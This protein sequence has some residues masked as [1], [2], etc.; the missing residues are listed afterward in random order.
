MTCRKKSR[1]VCDCCSYVMYFNDDEVR[2]GL[3]LA[4]QSCDSC[5]DVISYIFQMNEYLG[6]LRKEYA[7]LSS[8]SNY[9]NLFRERLLYE[10]L[11]STSEK[12][13][14]LV[15][16]LNI[17]RLLCLRLLSLGLPIGLMAW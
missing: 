2:R 8:I 6:S 5:I 17:Y 12:S 1:L 14:W 15:H 3:F 13:I 11:E 16:K 4:K 7:V 9:N 10:I